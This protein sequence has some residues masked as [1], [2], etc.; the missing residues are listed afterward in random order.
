MID[1]GITGV[2]CRTP[3]EFRAEFKKA[4]NIATEDSRD[5]LH[6]FVFC[7]YHQESAYAEVVYATVKNNVVVFFLNTTQYE[8]SLDTKFVAQSFHTND[9][10]AYMFF[11]SVF[12]SD[13]V[14]FHTECC[15]EQGIYYRV[16]SLNNPNQIAKVDSL[17]KS[18]NLPLEDI[19]PLTDVEIMEVCVDF[20]DYTSKEFS[21]QIDTAKRNDEAYEGIEENPFQDRF[22]D[23][24]EHTEDEDP[25]I[26]D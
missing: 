17:T 21:R 15:T 14:Y 20:M 22:F 26:Y 24:G 13:D 5:G 3:D 18:N 12:A 2:W 8:L 7:Q 23:R 19:V 10:S 4:F 1:F 6:S 16:F 25:E 9:D 11:T